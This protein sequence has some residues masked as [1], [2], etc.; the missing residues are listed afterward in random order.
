MPGEVR[1][2]ECPAYGRDID[3][4]HYLCS[5]FWWNT[6]LANIRPQ[7]KQSREWQTRRINFLDFACMADARHFLFTFADA[8]PLWLP[9][10]ANTRFFLVMALYTSLLWLTCLVDTQHLLVMSLHARPLRRP[11]LAN[12]NHVDTKHSTN[13]TNYPGTQNSAR[14]HDVFA[15]LVAWYLSPQSV[16]HISCV[17]LLH[18]MTPF[19]FSVACYPSAP[20]STLF[21]TLASPPPLSFFCFTTSC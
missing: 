4:M 1:V 11:Y 10:L 17:S 9:G 8:C 20:W 5:Y 14:F 7:R 2:L 12:I 15:S 3:C 18:L 16:S 13:L 6:F 19:F 21:V